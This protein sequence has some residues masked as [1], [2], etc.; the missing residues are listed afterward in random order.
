VAQLSAEARQ[1]TETEI[2]TQM[3][4]PAYLDRGHR[5]HNDAVDR[6]AGLYLKLNTG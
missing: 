1:R 6:V 3:R 5:N 2:A 4:Q